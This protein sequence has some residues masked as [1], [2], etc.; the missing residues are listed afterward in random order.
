MTMMQGIS[1]RPY[2]RECLGNITGARS[3]GI[4]RQLIVQATGMGKAVQA[5][6]VPSALNIPRGK[7]SLFLVHRDELAYQAVEKFRKYNPQL[8][9][10]LEKASSRAYD[11]DIVVASVPS[12]GRA[13]CK[14]VAGATNWEYCD[15]LRRFNP[16]DF[17]LVQADEAHHIPGNDSWLTVLRYFHVLKGEPNE[18]RNRLLLGWTATP[19][20]ADNQ[21]LESVFDEIVSS[22]GIRE[23]ITDGWLAPIVAYRLETEEDVSR[24]RLQHG[25]FA[26]SDLASAINTPARNRLIAQKYAELCPNKPA[27][28]FTANIAHSEDL[29]EELRAHG[30]NA[31]AISGNTPRDER[32]QLISDFKSGEVHALCSCGVLNEGTDLPNA[33]AGFMCRPTK[34]GLL[35]RQQI[36]RILR[37]SPAPEELATMTAA[38]GYIKLYA[39]IVDV[40][41][42]SGRHDLV[43]APSLFGLRSDWDANG[44]ALVAQAEEIERLEREYPGCDLRAASSIGELH[45]WL[46]RVDL[47]NVPETPEVIR[48]ISRFAWLDGAAGSYRLSLPGCV[49]LSVQENAL[50]HYDI[51][52][53]EKGFS[54]RLASVADLKA[55][56]AR[57]E[58]EVPDDARRVVDN[59]AKWRG[60]VPTEKQVET[61]YKFDRELKGRFPDPAAL[62]K[63]CVARFNEGIAEYSRGAISNRIGALLAQRASTPQYYHG[64][65]RAI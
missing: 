45:A 52:R 8:T 44:D 60:N 53:N 59:G 64:A 56:I 25:D 32:A 23:G 14:T 65:R 34:S 51:Y 21:G 58:L 18:D 57:A 43:V 15:R 33:E 19:Q 47:I 2:Q 12:I 11:A 5:A 61:L 29:A 16:N 13:T 39:L 17:A 4:S 7:R 22:Y 50:G 28:F 46:Q 1:L 37:P 20:R 35:Y 63:F 41:D 26:V 55:A 31:W 10:G 40:A 62:H 42:V 6:N 38:G 3:R 49:V 24:V 48:R 30:F 27:I 9:V 36:G 54:A